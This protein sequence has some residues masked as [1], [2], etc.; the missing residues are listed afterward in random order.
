MH[1]WP[2]PLAKTAT[3]ACASVLV[4]EEHVPSRLPQGMRCYLAA[5]FEQMV[6]AEN[7]TA[8]GQLNG[9]AMIS[10]QA[11]ERWVCIHGACTLQDT[12]SMC[13]R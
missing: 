11:N 10:L 6:A 4:R 12:W 7:A 2:S 5:G 13:S 3:S 1:H 9:G 8:R